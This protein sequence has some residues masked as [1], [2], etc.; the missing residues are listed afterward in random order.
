[1]QLPWD[2]VW[3]PVN[4][5]QWGLAGDAILSCLVTPD[6]TRQC[7][8]SKLCTLLEPHS[9]YA[10]TYTAG[11]LEICRL[12]CENRPTRQY[13]TSYK[14]RKQRSVRVEDEEGVARLRLSLWAPRRLLV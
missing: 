1:M 9:H 10:R 11:V 14:H 5:G 6:L 7:Q 13:I 8:N 2:V 3:G 12:T 4:N